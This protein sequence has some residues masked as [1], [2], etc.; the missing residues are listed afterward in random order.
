[1]KYIC[2][3]CKPGLEIIIQKMYKEKIH[4]NFNGFESVYFFVY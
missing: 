1:M 4:C 2:G 3:M